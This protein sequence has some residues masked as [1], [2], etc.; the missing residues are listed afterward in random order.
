LEQYFFIKKLGKQEL[1]YSEGIPGKR[2]GQYFLISKNHLDFFP[3][4]SRDILNDLQII[5]I[6]SH[7]S[8]FPHQAKYVYNND[9]YHGSTARQP[10]DEYRININLKI[11]PEREIFLK[12]DIII[13]KK[14]H[15]KNEFSSD[16]QGFVITRYRES[17]DKDDYVFLN[18]II[19]NKS[20]NSHSRNYCNASQ[21]D[22]S[23]LKNHRERLF[24]RVLSKENILPFVDIGLIQTI[25]ENQSYTQ[26][27]EVSETDALEWQIRRLI[28]DKYEYKCAVS[29]IGFKWKERK[30]QV[31]RNTSSDLEGAHIKPRAHDGPYTVDNII[32]L[33]KSIHT[34]FDRGIFTIDK[35]RKVVMHPEALNQ[36][37]LSNF[38]IYN[39]KPLYIPEDISLSSEYIKHHRTHIYGKFITGEPIRRM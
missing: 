12:D 2:G 39:G 29:E 38:Q 3:S 14:E 20:L 24:K 13:F 7:N 22:L 8:T 18:N 37:S 33:N 32:P 21:S 25:N 31:A 27:E 4:L 5:N 10:R 9:R 19:K 26:K 23:P 36:K 35:N 28:L 17:E 30:G 15:F 6:V 11:N 16:E 1:A 34:I